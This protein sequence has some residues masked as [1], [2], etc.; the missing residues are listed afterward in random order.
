ML[1]GVVINNAIVLVDYSNL[2]RRERGLEFLQA[3]KIAGPTR[4]RPILMSTLTTVLGLL[5]MMIST[6]TGSETMRGL[7]TVVVFG[8]MLSTLVTLIFVPVI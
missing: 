6:A 4:L 3:M 5:P 1:A 7:A 8:L 2:L